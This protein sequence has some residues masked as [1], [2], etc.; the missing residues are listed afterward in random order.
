MK[1]TLITT[2]NSLGDIINFLK[3][4]YIICLHAGYNIQY[5]FSKETLDEIIDEI[6]VYINFQPINKYISI[7]FIYQLPSF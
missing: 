5:Y 4:G 1:K 7:N 6:I 2:K 3:D